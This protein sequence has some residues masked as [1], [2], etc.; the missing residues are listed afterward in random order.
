MK[1]ALSGLDLAAVVRE[2]SSAIKGARLANIYQAGRNKFLLKLRKPGVTHR[3]LVELGVRANLTQREVEVPERPPPFCMGLRKDLRGG[4]VVDVRQ[5]GLDRVL[6]LTV[7]NRG[8]RYKLVFELFGDGNFILIGPD[9]RIKRVLRPKEMRDRKLLVGEEF[10]YPP[11]PAIDITAP[12]G[13]DMSGL[14]ELGDLEAVRGLS[15]LTG[16]SGPYAEEVLL[17][18]GVEK[19]KPCSSLSDAELARLREAVAG[20]VRSVLE[21]PL[22]P[23]IVVNGGRWVDVIPVRLLRYAGLEERIFPT[24]N[25]AVDAYFSKLEADRL[26][27]AALADLEEQVRKL[28]RMLAAQEEAVERFRAEAETKRRIADAIYAH[29]NELNFLLDALRDLKETAGSW[30]AVRGKLGELRARGP[31]FSWLKDLLPSGPSALLDLDGLEVSLDLR[32]SA[33]ETAAGYYELAKKARKKAEGAA[34]AL[35][36]T[37]AR[38]EELKARLRAVPI[39]PARPTE[40]AEALPKAVRPKK[41][42][43]YERFRWFTSSD[44]FLVVAGKDATT[45]ELLVKRYAGPGDLLLHAELPGAPFVLV[46][47][48]GQEVPESTLSEAAQ[49]AI[50]YS[51]AWKYGLGAATAICFKPEQAKKIGPH[52]EKL[53]KGSF[54]VVGKKEYI[55]GVKPQLAIG[56]SRSGGRAELIIGPVGAV[57]ARA[58]AYVLIGPGDVEASRLVAEV[59]RA[60]EAKV[61]KLELPREELE[62]AKSLVPYGR[63][64]LLR[65]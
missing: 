40:R 2:L 31:P 7:A 25:E 49:M 43:W 39:R 59:I 34:K 54:Y 58:E 44:G 65:A 10:K 24:M 3:L 8:D 28:E 6:E 20:L 23:R 42:A 19:G 11:Q 16:L 37:R 53:P 9:G 18:A 27:A 56:V 1:E 35:E 64:R 33:Q 46:K 22:K 12:D 45:N 50:T 5:H 30:E 47:A 14:R 61:G 41:R 13:P 4:V 29:L 51:R 55:R 36:E 21:G 52:G 57:E 15:R 48:G 17:R 38:L 60:L 62:R 63:G 26:G 32:R